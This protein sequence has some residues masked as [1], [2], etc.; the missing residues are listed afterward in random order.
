MAVSRPILLLGPDP[1]HV[2]DLVRE[3]H[4]G[5]QISHGDVDGAVNTIKQIVSTPREELHAMGTRARVLIDR[6]L[7]KSVLCGRFCDVVER[8]LLAAQPQSSA[9]ATR[10]A[11]HAA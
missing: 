5:W 2:S 11:E 3:H 1:C 10:P 4:L 7:S 6:E 9:A 8:G